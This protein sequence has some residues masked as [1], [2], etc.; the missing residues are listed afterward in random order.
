MHADTGSLASGM[1]M[2]ISEGFLHDPKKCGFHF[3]GKSAQVLG[4]FELHVDFATLGET[5][6]IPAESRGQTEL[7]EQG[8][9]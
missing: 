3:A 9:V 7:I 5:F 1:A 4:E 2:D 6:N 8:R